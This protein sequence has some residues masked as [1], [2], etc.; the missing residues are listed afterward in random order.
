[1]IRPESKN[2]LP[3]NAKLVFKGTI[4]DTY[5]WPQKM[6]DGTTIIFEKLKRPDTVNVIPVDKDGKVIMSIQSQP[7]REEFIGFFGGRLDNNE[8]PLSG[9]ER[10]LLEESGYQAKDWQL[11]FSTQMADKIDYVVYTFIVKGL[12]KV[13]AQKLDV[14]ERIKLRK[15]SFNEFL[16]IASTEKFRDT[17]VTLQLYKALMDPKKMKEL[18]KLFSV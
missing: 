13:Q 10:E 14:G 3:K 17:E 5:Q 7:N 16:K 8:D 12:V 15:V 2:P 6:Y 9:G 1:M 11:W 4:F 18:K